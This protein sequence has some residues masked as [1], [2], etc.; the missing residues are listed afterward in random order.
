MTQTITENKLIEDQTFTRSRVLLLLCSLL[1]CI[2]LV[3]VI[4]ALADMRNSPSPTKYIYP[5]AALIAMLIASRIPYRVFELPGKVKFIS[6]IQLMI[7]TSIFLLI[8][9]DFTPLSYGPPAAK[10][11]IRI[12]LGPLTVMF[13]PSE[14][15]KWSLIIYQA[16]FMYLHV[17]EGKKLSFFHFCKICF[18]SGIIILLILMNDFGT[19]AFL[20]AM[21][22]LMLIFGGANL[23]H[24]IGSGLLVLP[25]LAY[26]V[27]KEEY[28]VNRLLSFMFP[29]KADPD[30]LYQTNRSLQAL[31]SGGIWGKGIGSGTT[32][33]GHLPVDSSD[34]IFSVIGEETGLIGTILILMLFFLFAAVGF[35]TLFRCRDNFGKLLAAGITCGITLQAV[36]NI[37]VVTS[38]LP[39]KGIPLPLVSSG[40]TSILTS[41]AVVGILA[42]IAA[43][44]EGKNKQI[45]TNQ[46]QD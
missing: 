32:K 37:G 44:R 39:N 10:R 12:P 19:A 13:Q 43:G 41:A 15:A 36:M 30:L 16:A 8:L 5:A 14:L 9:A 1:I 28:R 3:F 33:W 22:G 17:K 26:Y 42:A 29:E 31:G 7:L 21:T 27:M 6:L 2:G 38:V 20:S 35:I 24:I 11:W 40:G 46:A 34:F 45:E 18:V 4:S 25:V 23:L